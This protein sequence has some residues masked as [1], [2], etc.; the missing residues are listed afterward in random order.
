MLIGREDGLQSEKMKERCSRRAEFPG[1]VLHCQAAAPAGA[2]N[3]IT[4]VR[5][6][7]LK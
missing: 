5:R 1:A 6:G 7:A 2:V 4:A 3:C